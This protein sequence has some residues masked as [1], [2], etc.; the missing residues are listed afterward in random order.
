MAF[1]L[2]GFATLWLSH[3]RIKDLERRLN[4]SRSGPINV[5]RGFRTGKY[6]FEAQAPRSLAPGAEAELIGKLRSLGNKHSVASIS[7][8]SRNQGQACLTKIFNKSGWD[9]GSNIAWEDTGM[10]P[11]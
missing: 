5:P 1:I 2:S 6:L 7:Y 8:S 9:T 10:P 3:N 4:P 11:R